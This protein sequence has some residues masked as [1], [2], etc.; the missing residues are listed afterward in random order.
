MPCLAL[1]Y[2]CPREPKVIQSFKHGQTHTVTHTQAAGSVRGDVNHTNCQN[3][4]EI[5]GLDGRFVE[6]GQYVCKKNLC[7]NYPQR[8]VQWTGVSMYARRTCVRFTHSVVL[9]TMYRVLCTA[10][11]N[12]HFVLEVKAKCSAEGK[13]KLLLRN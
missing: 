12:V 8:C 3:T 4:G 13:D 10:H 7:Q 11:Y 6:C 2:E 1:G 5:N 9:C